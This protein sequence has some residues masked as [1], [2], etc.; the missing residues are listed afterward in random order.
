MEIEVWNE[1]AGKVVAEVA[2]AY[3]V[4][5]GLLIICMKRTPGFKPQINTLS[6]AHNFGLSTLSGWMF[7]GA[8]RRLLANFLHHGA[9][10][11][12]LW[13]NE[14]GTDI[15]ADKAF[16]EGKL[17]EGTS[18][19]FKWFFLS[20]FVEY[21]DTLLLLLRRGYAFKVRWYLQVWHHATTAGVAWCGW[22]FNAPFAWL[23]ILSN[24]FVHFF[25]YFYF[26]VVTVDRRWRSIG[27]F[28]TY[29]QIVQLLLCVVGAWSLLALQ[30]AYG[31]TQIAENSL[32]C[33]FIGAVYT[34]YLILF[35]LMFA[36]RAKGM[37]REL[38]G[39]KMK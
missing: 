7:F 11:R 18:L 36:E 14:P 39:A 19:Y 4:M 9:D 27:H 6:A 38:R 22:W 21:G 5:V 2:L 32:P 10:P 3:L 24:T 12:L 20:K 33:I 23:G 15:S 30:P 17:T 34:S 28:V 29:V 16:A 35:G 13:C 25:M 31:C 1:N 26:A 37:Q 8:S